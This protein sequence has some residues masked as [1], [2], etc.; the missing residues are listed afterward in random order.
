VSVDE[1]LATSVPDIF[2]AG[3]IARWPDRYSGGRIRVEHWVMAERQAQVAAL[4]MMGH[5]QSYI[6]VPFFWTERLSSIGRK[7]SND[8]SRACAR[9]R[10]RPRVVK[11]VMPVGIAITFRPRPVDE[12]GSAGPRADQ[13]Y[14]ERSSRI[15]PLAEI[16]GARTFLEVRAKSRAVKRCAGLQ[17]DMTEAER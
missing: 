4:N 15:V 11:T 14:I 12:G 5:C 17:Q 13:S 9:T 3:D 2:T 6:A 7:F 1:H 10:T 16:V 8:F